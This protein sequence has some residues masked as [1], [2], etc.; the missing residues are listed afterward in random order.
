[1]QNEWETVGLF[2]PQQMVITKKSF[3]SIGSD[4]MEVS[5]TLIYKILL[6]FEYTIQSLPT[7][8]S[9]KQLIKDRIIIASVDSNDIIEYLQENHAT[10]IL[11]TKRLKMLEASKLQSKK[12]LIPTHV[13][14]LAHLVELY[15]AK[16][17]FKQ[18]PL[19]L[20]VEYLK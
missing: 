5:S 10:Y 4:S 16:Y 1:M 8:P 3:S 6:Q 2:I 15:T 18:I 14:I 17:L 12:D 11:Y 19:T 9:V 20:R 7:I 13:D